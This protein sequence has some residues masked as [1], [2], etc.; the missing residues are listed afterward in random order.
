MN[1]ILPEWDLDLPDW[2]DLPEWD[3][4]LPDWKTSE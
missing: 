1:W 3:L 2:E 4:N